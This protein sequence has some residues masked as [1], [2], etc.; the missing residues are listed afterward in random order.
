VDGV[1]GRLI[2]RAERDPKLRDDPCQD[3]SRGC[4]CGEVGVAQGCWERV[5]RLDDDRLVIPKG[6]GGH[7][8]ESYERESPP[9]QDVL[10]EVPRGRIPR[11]G[12]CRKMLRS[13]C[14]VC[15][16]EAFFTLLHPVTHQEEH[17]CGSCFKNV[18]GG[19]VPVTFRSWPPRRD[20]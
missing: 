16:K 2:L 20:D 14:F 13:K 17:Y 11:R 7:G 5:G 6:F 4:R 18:R 3:A 1:L 12:L 8:D 15:Q 10:L 9:S 19:I